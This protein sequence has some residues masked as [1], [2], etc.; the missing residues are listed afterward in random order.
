MGHPLQLDR[1]ALE[2][3]RQ[4]VKSLRRRDR[5]SLPIRQ[6]LDL[7]GNAPIGAGITIDFEASR[8]LGNELIVVRV[9]ESRRDSGSAPRLGNLSRREQEVAM[10]IAAG[11]SN[12]LIADRLC[13]ATSTAKDHV[14]HILQK[15]GLPNRAA[16]A[17]VR[18]ATE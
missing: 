11:L 1:G 16:I 12:K 4:A 14:H 15:T 10:L 7:A 5:G 8:D 9:P 17:A 6:I 18:R 3:I 13:I 2:R